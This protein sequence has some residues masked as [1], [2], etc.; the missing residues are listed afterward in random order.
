MLELFSYTFIQN[1]FFAG[2]IVAVICA[3]LGLFIVL[4][5]LSFMTDGIAHGLPMARES[6]F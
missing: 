4:R 3:V 6:I 5:K 2:T 1:A